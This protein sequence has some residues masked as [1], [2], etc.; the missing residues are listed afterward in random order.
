MDGYSS[1]FTGANQIPRFAHFGERKSEDDLVH[2]MLIEDMFEILDFSKN[3]GGVKHW[4]GARAQMPQHLHSKSPVSSQGAR[5]RL[6][7]GTASH[8]ESVANTTPAR[9]GTP[10]VADCGPAGQNHSKKGNAGEK[11]EDRATVLL[12]LD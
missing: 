4:L 9:Y 10:Q 11:E 8:D 12:R 7:L 1:F 2:D 6:R 3:R 5:K